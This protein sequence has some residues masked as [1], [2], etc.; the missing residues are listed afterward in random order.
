MA[1]IV[2]EIDRPDGVLPVTIETVGGLVAEVKRLR[3]LTEQQAAS[4]AEKDKGL[5]D[6]KDDVLR[7]HREKME[8]YER[9]IAAESRAEQAERALAEAR[10]VRDLLAWLAGKPHLELSFSGWDESDVWEVH[11]VTGGRDDREWNLIAIGA[12]PID[13]LRTAARAFV[14]QHGSDSREGK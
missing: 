5:S 1:D 9:A 8:Q 2:S 14:A 7:L 10:E 11:S 3:A 13:A 6:A 12:T 4:L